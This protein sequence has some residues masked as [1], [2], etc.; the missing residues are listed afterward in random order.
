MKRYSLPG[1]GHHTRR[2]H[3]RTAMATATR[4]ALGTPLCDLLGI[5]YPIC[6]AGRGHVARSALAAAVSEA[7]GLGVIAAA[8]FTPAELR[9]E[10]Q[11]VRDLTD[12]P[13]GVDILFATVRAAGEEAELFTDA[14]RGWTEVTLEERVPVLIA[15]LGNPGPVTGDAHRQG[16]KVMALCGN[17]K[18]AR[19]HVQNGVDVVIAQG[20]EAGGHT[21]R[22]GGLVLIP[23]VID[24]VSPV[25]VVASGGIADGRGVVAA[26]SLGAVG[27]WLG[28]RFI[29]TPEAYGH[30]NYK[31]K[32]V[33]I[34]E[35]GT[36]VT[37]GAS[38]KP[39]RLIRN[40][41]TREWERREAEIL[42]FPIQAAR[43][44]RPPAILAPQH[45]DIDNGNAPCGPSA[46]LIRDIPP[47]RAVV[48]SL[49]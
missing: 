8:Q 16:M 34:D 10:I 28:T 22:I 35:E 12:K 19:D 5:T 3:W 36:V 9:R 40:N 38:G 25:P 21:G 2:R 6:Q 17:V 41:F 24:A 47:A 27:V 42:P 37:R 31:N 11:R 33:A 30:V 1:L 7:G 44:G 14:V 13:F 45:G 48:R 46:G 18:Q 15:G 32:V 39:C 29:A 20:H 26:L 49:I 43:V 23:A 4:P